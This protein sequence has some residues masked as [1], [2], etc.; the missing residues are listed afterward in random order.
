MTSKEK[1]IK[2]SGTFVGLARS[3]SADGPRPLGFGGFREII[4]FAG[5]QTCRLHEED[6]ARAVVCQ[7]GGIDRLLMKNGE[8]RKAGGMSFGAEGEI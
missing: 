5:P 8:K 3:R 7:P 6:G 4:T 2:E 1:I